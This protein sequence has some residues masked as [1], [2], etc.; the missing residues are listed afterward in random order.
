M[1]K[2]DSTDILMMFVRDRQPIRGESSSELDMPG[3][4][5]NSLLKGFKKGHLF[6]VDSFTFAVGIDDDDDEH[7]AAA[8]AAKGRAGK[9]GH[10]TTGGF[11][12]WR[13]GG[14]PA[15][16]KYPVDIQPIR[17]SRA[18]DRASSVL[19]QNC[20]DCA[21][22]DSATLV[23][24]KSAGS[25]AAGEPYLRFDFNGVL[26]TGIDWSN[27]DQVKESCS[28]I[29]RSVTVHYRPQMP[30]GTLGA[31]VPGFWSMLPW[32]RPVVL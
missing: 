31:I 30:D 8:P 10:S 1:A 20:V 12:R 19:L 11:K 27:D 26:M 15:A 4:P 23:K 9:T 3:R 32:E 7:R 28:F 16:K 21:T 5:R 24:R 22:Y 25:A 18:I 14:R 2:G 29:C 13:M 17:F 6:E